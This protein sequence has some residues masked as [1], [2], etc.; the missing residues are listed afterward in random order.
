M[1]TVVKGLKPDGTKCVFSI[2][3]YLKENLDEAIKRVTKR[4]WDYVAVVSGYSGVGKSNF[5]Q[6]C[7]RYCS[8]WFDHTYIAF[9]DDEFIKITNECPEFSSVVL[10]ESFQSLNTKVTNS[11]AFLRIV[12]HLQLIRQKHL[13]IFLCL[14]NFFDLSKGI[15]IFRSSHLFLV[16]AD[17]KGERGYFVAF[18]RDAKRNLYIKGGKYL[19]YHAVEGNFYGRFPKQKAIDENAY[20][21]M[22][23]KNLLEQEKTIDRTTKARQV[24]NNFV[25][26]LFNTKKWKKETIAKAGGIDRKT[27]YNI[28][29]Q[30]GK[31]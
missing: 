6:G 21:A 2:D 4:N 1:V 27:V 3:G 9:S 16:Y 10:D 30:N 31:K 20:L 11:I 28:L 5:A 15:A 18:D 14:P 8:E 12:N 13:F 23:R 25:R 22:K 17:D 24:R 7:A 26:Y 29:K 19:N